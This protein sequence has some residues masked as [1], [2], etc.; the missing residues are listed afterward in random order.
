MKTWA[1]KVFLCLCLIYSPQLVQEK[2]GD[3]VMVLTYHHIDNEGNGV[4]ISEKQFAAH[5]K[6]LK[7]NNYNVISMDEFLSFVEG[8]A[9]V[10]PRSVLITFDDGYESNYTKA[11]PI[12]KQYGFVGTIFIVVSSTETPNP[13]NIPHLSWGQL[14]E[15]QGNGWAIGSHTYDL[16]YMLPTKNGEKPA[17]ITQMNNESFSDYQARIQHDLKKSFLTVERYLDTHQP[18]FAF[19]YGAYNDTV[20]QTGKDVGIRYFFTTQEGFALPGQTLIP[21]INAG[22][23]TITPEILL[24]KLQ[25]YEK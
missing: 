2:D 11:Y 24:S 9:S 8:K 19:P 6:I 7:D 16:H 14:I 22:S 20:V 4:T 12:M 3:R 1:L 13:K 21:R 15:L 25:K 18:I 17:L 5:M 23:P 10:P